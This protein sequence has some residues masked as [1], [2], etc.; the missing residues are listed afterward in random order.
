M[1]RGIVPVA[2]IGHSAGE[3]VAACLAGTFSLEDA[4]A[5]MATRGELVDGAPPG[6]MLAVSLDEMTLRKRLSAELDVAVVTAP[7]LCVVAGP[8]GLVDAFRISAEADGI[9][10]RRLDLGVGFHSS[11]MD[12]AAIALKARIARVKLSPP[13]LRFVSN[14]TGTWITD[15]EATS[16]EYWAQHLRHT[17]RFGD[18]IDL[19][20]RS[21]GRPAFL[22]VGPGRTLSGPV[23]RHPSRSAGQPVITS[24]R[25]PADQAD[26][27]AVFNLALGRL[28]AGGVAVDATVLFDG[29]VRRRVPLPTYPFERKRFWIDPVVAESSPTVKRAKVEDWLYL[30]SWRRSVHPAPAESG[31]ARSVMVIG[32]GIPLADHCGTALRN[33]GHRVEMLTAMATTVGDVDAIIDFRACRTV[34]DTAAEDDAG[35][36]KVF[37]DLLTVAKIVTGSKRPVG[38]TVVTVGATQV[39]DSDPIEPGK[40]AAFGLLQ[41]LEQEYPHIRCRAVDVNG[42]D[43]AMAERVAAEA[44][45]AGVDRFVALRGRHRWCREYAAAGSIGSQPLL[46][47]RGVYVITGGV[48][49]VG[50]TIARL[51]A[52][53]VRARLVLITRSRGLDPAL[54]AE[55]EAAGAEVWVRH[56]DVADETAMK[57]VLDEVTAAFGA[58][59]GVIHAAGVTT[60]E[61][62]F[63]PIEETNHEQVRAIFRPKVEGTLVLER[64]LRG[65]PID[66]CLLISS[67]ASTLGGLGLSAY[68]AASHV[69]DAI[70]A[71][72]RQAGR[73]WTSSNWDGWPSAVSDSPAGLRQS[74]IEAFTMSADEAQRALL[75]V[76]ACQTE[77]VVVSAGDL[78][79]RLSRWVGPE[80][81]AD[82]EG[83]APVSDRAFDGTPTEVAVLSAVEDVL[84][85]RPSSVRD[86]FFELGGDSL[87]GSR[88][89][90]RLSRR[91]GV[92]LSVR[93]IFADPTIAGMA[94]QVD[95]ARA[96]GAAAVSPI[97]RIPDAPSYAVSSAQRRLWILHEIDKASA[98]Y[99]VALHQRLDG[100]L[101]VDAMRA[102][103]RALVD[104]HESL[105]TTFQVIDGEPRQAIHRT[106]ATVLDTHD[107]SDAADPETAARAL[108]RS[109]SE[110]FDLEQ[111]PLVRATLIRLAPE[112][113]VLLF[114]MH[115]IVADG[116]SVNVIGR[117]LARFYDAARTGAAEGLPPLTI[118]YRDFAAWQNARLDAP[119]G[120]PDRDYWHAKL[121]GTLPVID[122]IEDLP[123]PGVLT[124]SGREHVVEIPAHVTAA[125]AALGQRRNASLF[126]VLLAA[127]K[128]YLYRATGQTDVIIGSPSA[129]RVHAD[130][131]D[132]IGCFLNTL[133][134]RDQIDPG[135]SFERLLDQVRVTATEAFDHQEYPFERL[136]AEL[137]LPRDPSRSPIFDVVM[138]LQN[139][140]ENALAIEGVQARAFDEHNHTAKVD[141][142]FNF[143]P[144]GA[145]LILGIEYNTDLFLDERIAAIASQF[146]ALLRSIVQDP[147]VAIDALSLM[148]GPER[149]RILTAFND[150]RVARSAGDSVIGLF[151]AH[152]V[153]QPDAAAV[154]HGE[155]SLS[156]RGLDER[157]NQLARHFAEGA[158]L[159]AG[160]LAII[161]VPSGFDLVASLLAV[162]K[163]RAAAVLVEPSITPERLT[164]L[165]AE[166][167]SRIV[168]S[169]D[170]LDDARDAINARSTAPIDSSGRSQDDD[171]LVFFTSGSTG[172]PKGVR[173]TNR[174]IVN[175]LDWFARYFNV[176]AGD[177]LAAEDRADVCGL[178]CGTV[179]AVDHHWRCGAPAS[180]LRDHGRPRTP[181][182]V[183][184]RQ[185]RD[186]SAIRSGSVRGTRYGGRRGDAVAAPR[187]DL[188]RFGDQAPTALSVQDLQPVRLLGNH[189]TCDLSGHHC[190]DATGPGSDWQ[191]VAEH[192]DLHPGFEHGAVPL[193]CAR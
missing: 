58:I 109:H 169:A 97:T 144:N 47:E 69:L 101:D 15:A 10:C 99:H 174:G 185:R 34:S 102:A 180:R 179:A 29:Q 104:R 114:T 182:R 18:G 37:A 51:L 118:H 41:S 16:P 106:P 55:L 82:S 181:G 124:T 23:L 120:E 156:Y 88:M 138:I 190:A 159:G 54:R 11:L 127:L 100:P 119:A 46:K 45:N 184:P 141:L 107:V 9:E 6:A 187:A 60:P 162:L 152:V 8:A 71:R 75:R 94:A 191:A 173:L 146:R 74:G 48:G 130:L 2:L 183:V 22:E 133:A 53:T 168:V 176:T 63:R 39:A 167:R 163:L 131:D 143:K 7:G 59:D 160:D 24:T 153:A 85:T 157:S 38:L 81:E 186:H 33:L 136:V 12:E 145:G 52:R 83:V 93:M 149:Q 147:S 126:M 121:G 113:H 165:A 170:A 108:A 125:L 21:I 78:Q 132:Q 189:R 129:G 96:G 4:L 177:V 80:P 193:V 32:A 91:M 154:H 3:Y 17:V 151:E 73:P 178:H 111:G 122:L 95:L 44:M 128:T 86:N 66:F 137:Q 42:D 171:V 5:V 26:D 90:A 64:L 68:G 142:S 57:A 105:R 89:M 43:E 92:P 84:G 115:H 112:R 35:A 188:E 67:N 175:E 166:S 19:L 139:D 140:V 27:H 31:A 61:V 79:A 25:H 116:V 134:L 49:D 192:V 77:R 135:G 103:M 76:L 164:A 158:S 155:R 70:A 172:I 13:R 1:S 50:A 20:C 148:S 123:R 98:A 40:A 56:A 150:T 117:D 65:R 110:P 36:A 14:L 62:L 30:P 72:S 87:L 161:A 28:W